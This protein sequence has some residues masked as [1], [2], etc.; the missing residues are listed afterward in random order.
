M[1]V[2]KK[3][4]DEKA[5]VVATIDGYD[6]YHIPGG[7]PFGPDQCEFRRLRFKR[8]SVLCAVLPTEHPNETPL[9][10]SADIDMLV[11]LYRKDLIE[12]RSVKVEDA[13]LGQWYFLDTD[14]KDKFYLHSIIYDKPYFLRTVKRPTDS[15]YVGQ[16]TEVAIDGD[17][18]QLHNFGKTLKDTIYYA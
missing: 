18:K 7:Y 14:G 4:L 5:R 1:N 9:D 3:L 13:A 10:V 15:R 12:S 11:E 6:F 16:G 17:R 8:N 2:R